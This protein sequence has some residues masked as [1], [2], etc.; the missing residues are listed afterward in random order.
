MMGRQAR[1]PCAGGSGSAGGWALVVVLHVQQYQPSRVVER[2]RQSSRRTT[3]TV[4]RCVR[5]PHD[6]QNMTP[7][8]PV[9]PSSS[10]RPFIKA[11][12]GARTKQELSVAASAPDSAWYAIRRRSC[13]RSLA[14]SGQSREPERGL[15]T[16]C[17]RMRTQHGS[18]MTISDA[19]CR[20][21]PTVPAPT[22]NSA[23]V[24][25]TSL[26][27]MTEPSSRHGSR[28]VP[29]RRIRSGFGSSGRTPMDR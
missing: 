25:A 10:S 3:T 4:S 9:S 16:R 23:G 26:S 2:D 28:A 24:S 15:Q 6:L 11:R 8:V 17:K 13:H 12:R 27:A 22:T 7:S 20:S 14:L 1:A 21:T 5:P 18:P 19:L 29:G